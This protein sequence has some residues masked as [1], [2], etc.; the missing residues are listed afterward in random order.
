MLDISIMTII[1]SLL[2]QITYKFP[3]LLSKQIKN[4]CNQIS[5]ALSFSHGRYFFNLFFYFKKGNFLHS[6]I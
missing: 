6:D 4:K 3:F 2:I 1:L 5:V